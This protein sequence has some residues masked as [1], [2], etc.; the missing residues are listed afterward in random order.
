MSGFLVTMPN[1]YPVS[2]VV[3]PFIT[4]HRGP[5]KELVEQVLV[6]RIGGIHNVIVG[7]QTAKGEL[8][9]LVFDL[10][11]MKVHSMIV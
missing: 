2:L 3:F 8:V 4:P 6:P 9:S 7:N 11:K 5:I 10:K 1:W